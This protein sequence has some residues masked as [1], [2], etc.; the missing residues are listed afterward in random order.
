MIFQMISEPLKVMFTMI[1]RLSIILSLRMKVLNILLVISI[2]WSMDRPNK[3]HNKHSFLMKTW[4]N[5][6]MNMVDHKK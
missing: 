4:L 5:L 2:A 3:I 6:C 1:S